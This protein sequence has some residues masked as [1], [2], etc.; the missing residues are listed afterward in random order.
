MGEEISCPQCGHAFAVSEIDVGSLQ[1]MEPDATKSHAMT[2]SG[3][4]CSVEA[5]PSKAGYA[6][7]VGAGALMV[8]AIAG[9]HKIGE[10]RGIFA[11]IA[12]LLCISLFLSFLPVFAWSGHQWARKTL[13]FAYRHTFMYLKACFTGGL[14]GAAGGESDLASSVAGAQAAEDDAKRKQGVGAATSAVAKPIATTV[15]RW[16][17]VSS[18]LLIGLAFTAPVPRSMVAADDT[19]PSAKSPQRTNELAAEPEPE[20]PPPRAKPPRQVLTIRPLVNFGT[21]VEPRDVCLS[22]D[23]KF[24]VFRGEL[25]EDARYRV[26]LN[27]R[28]S[29]K[30]PGPLIG[31]QTRCALSPDGR[32]AVVFGGDGFCVWNAQSGELIRAES[33]PRM[34]NGLLGSWGRLTSFMPDGRLCFLSFTDLESGRGNAEFV[35]TIDLPDGRPQKLMQRRKTGAL[36]GAVSPAGR[37]LALPNG[38]Q[39][40]RGVSLYNAQNGSRIRDLGTTNYFD[41]VCFSHD[42]KRMAAGGA[43]I[44]AVWETERFEELLVIKD[45]HGNGFRPNHKLLV[46]SPDGRYIISGRENKAVQIWDVD[47]GDLIRQ[48]PFAGHVSSLDITPEGILAVATS[49]RSLGLWK[50]EAQ[51]E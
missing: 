51:P 10:A 44:V 20:P 6:Q 22:P 46:L 13:A 9:S 39:S 3:L 47:H 23:A 32:F 35:Y 36:S 49:V 14:V 27:S 42:G 45:N 43:G 4:D 5:K 24:A 1:R 41:T 2:T 11:D 17:M 7:L 40:I 16:L 33:R 15:A 50:L 29:V 21:P 31:V 18:V 28:Q 34:T 19:A 12:G 30:L 8:V 26:D 37:F 25:R 38:G 48:M